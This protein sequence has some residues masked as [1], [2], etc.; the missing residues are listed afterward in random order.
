M[1]ANQIA[2][3]NM[4]E[5]VRSNKVRE[6]EQNRTNVANEELRLQELREAQRHNT[7]TESETNRS[8]LAKEME[9]NRHNVA[10]EN[11]ATRHNVVTER[12]TGRHNRVTENTANVV[13][14]ETA[15]HNQAT[16]TESARHNV[17]NENQASAEMAWNYDSREKD[18]QNQRNITDANNRAAMLRVRYQEGQAGLRT[19]W[20]TPTKLLSG[21]SRIIPDVVKTFSRLIPML[22]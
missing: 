21:G 2:Y 5:N 12:E 3:Q 19:I 15:R 16:E 9:N 4:L 18:R 22:K 17:A 1:T 13:A 8:N 10:T 20:E 14:Y 11:E 6:Q 7:T